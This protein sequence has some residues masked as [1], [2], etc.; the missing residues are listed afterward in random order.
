M[1][2]TCIKS[3]WRF[4]VGAFAAFLISLYVIP[5]SNCII[6]SISGTTNCWAGVSGFTWYGL[7]VAMASALVASPIVY[8]AIKR[9]FVTSFWAVVLGGM[10]IAALVA[11]A[12]AALDQNLSNLATLLGLGGFGACTA[13]LF[14]LLAV[15]NNVV[16]GGADK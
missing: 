11:I 15:R 16:V 2:K 1:N 12:L 5:I 13:A 4:A 9:G 10:C 3:R 7:P 14:W 8:V 6:A